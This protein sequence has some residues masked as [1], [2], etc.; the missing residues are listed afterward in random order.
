M[1]THMKRL[2]ICLAV[3]LF[4]LSP[5]M[6]QEA[7]HTAEDYIR[8]FRQFK[9]GQ[10]SGVVDLLKEDERWTLM[11]ELETSPAEDTEDKAI[12][13]NDAAY[14]AY[15][16]RYGIS[17]SNGRFLD[18]RDETYDICFIEKTIRSMQMATYSLDGRQGQQLFIVVPMEGEGDMLEVSLYTDD[19]RFAAR[20]DGSMYRI[21]VRKK[22]TSEEQLRLCIQNN[23]SGTVS[24]VIVNEHL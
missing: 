6:A 19:E 7:E 5:L 17:Y 13:I 21:H 11:D 16:D 14:N 22:L 9:E 2:M 3:G 23:G 12:G 4:T 15:A 8:L 20:Y 18:G 10:Q 24:Y 1:D